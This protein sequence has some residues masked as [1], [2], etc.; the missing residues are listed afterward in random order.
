MV[1]SASTSDTESRDFSSFAQ[2]DTNTQ[3]F[4]SLHQLDTLSTAGLRQRIPSEIARQLDGL[5]SSACNVRIIAYLARHEN[6]DV[7]QND[8]ERHCGIT[9]STASR[10]LN[11]MERKGLVRRIIPTFDARKRQVMLT[12]KSRR[13]VR[14]IEESGSDYFAAL[15]EGISPSDME[16][17]LRTIKR[18]LARSEQEAKPLD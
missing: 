8:V 6:E 17:T 7:Y 1:S 11:M 2:L 4:M 12:D 3:L 13:L 18:L 9:R 15:A 14:Q 5:P 10:V 16:T